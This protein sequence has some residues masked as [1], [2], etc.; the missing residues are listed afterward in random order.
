MK[1]SI[2]WD[3]TPCSSSQ[4]LF[5]GEHIASIF[6]VHNNPSKKPP[7]LCLLPAWCWCFAWLSSTLNMEATCSS[8]TTVDFQ[9]TTRNYIPEDRI[10]H[11]HRCEDLKSYLLFFL[12]SLFISC[13]PCFTHFLFSHLSKSINFSPRL[14]SWNKQPVNYRLFLPYGRELNM[15]LST[16]FNSAPVLKSAF[17]S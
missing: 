2:L 7:D 15:R 6:R 16:R 10:L 3:I 14:S 8:E 17:A 12:L 13:F 5:P 1:N 9:R 11:N 4:P